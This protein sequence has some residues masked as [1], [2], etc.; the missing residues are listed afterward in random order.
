MA[1]FLLVLPVL[2]LLVL[3]YAYAIAQVS[4]AFGP[5]AA[6][7]LFLCTGGLVIGLVILF[8]LLPFEL[9]HL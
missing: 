1:R 9:E 5:Q 8:L 3:G 2:A 7:F 4:V 6:Y